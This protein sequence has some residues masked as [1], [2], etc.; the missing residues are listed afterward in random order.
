MELEIFNEAN[1]IMDG[2]NQCNR[3]LNVVIQKQVDLERKQ[4]LTQI[5][6]GNNFNVSHPID[7]S[8]ET[9]KKI[10]ELMRVEKVNLLNDLDNKFKD[11]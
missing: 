9:L 6:F 2:I 10:L 1:T 8:E 11:L 5:R 3:D 7:L 4:G